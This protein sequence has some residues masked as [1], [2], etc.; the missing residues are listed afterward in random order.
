MIPY[1]LAW[2]IFSKVGMIGHWPI[3]RHGWEKW[4]WALI[5]GQLKAQTS[6]QALIAYM[7]L[8]WNLGY[9]IYQVTQ[10][11]IN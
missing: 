1:V 10:Y 9:K 2:M 4:K 8:K 5:L 7:V 6:Q 11:Y 3:L